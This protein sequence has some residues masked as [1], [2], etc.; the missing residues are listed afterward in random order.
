MICVVFA[1]I[2]DENT[3]E[4]ISLPDFDE[5]A[6]EL[7]IWSILMHR[8]EMAMLFW[9]EGKARRDQ[10]SHFNHININNYCTAGIL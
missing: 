9:E 2:L 5:P 8:Q 7:F 3:G 1:N 4:H 6:R 10:M